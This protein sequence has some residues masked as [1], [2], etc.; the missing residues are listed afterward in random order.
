MT[1]VEGDLM[2]DTIQLQG[3]GDNKQE[4]LNGA[5]FTVPDNGA[6]VPDVD[7]DDSDADTDK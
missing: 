4:K 5:P 1:T 2:S 3:P 6:W 7:P